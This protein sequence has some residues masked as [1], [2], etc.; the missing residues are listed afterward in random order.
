MFDFAS[1]AGWQKKGEPITVWTSLIGQA[2]LD[3]YEIVGNRTYLAVAESVCQWILKVPR[4]RANSGSC[5]SYA[6][7]KHDDETIHN[8]SMLA[9][10][11]LTRTAKYAPHDEY[12]QVA[13]EAI[14]YTCVRQRTDGSWF[15]G[16]GPKYRWIDSFHTGY[17]LDALKSYIEL[18]DDRSYQEVLKRGF[19]FYKNNFFDENG[20]PR[21]YHNR[22]FPIDSQCAA[23]AIDTLTFFSDQ[24]DSAMDLAV[25]VAKW[26]IMHMQDPTGYFYFMRYPGIVIKTPMIHWAQA[27]TYKALAYLL[28]KC[29]QS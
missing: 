1:R 19:L 17:V 2:F 28:S 15:Y 3:A 27:T 4:S 21:Y 16:E 22:T 20:R 7:S 5:I 23:Q 29:S 6:P 13:R 11:V 14:E 18:T 24:D 9:A 25:R 12:L 10:A 8:Q 26:T